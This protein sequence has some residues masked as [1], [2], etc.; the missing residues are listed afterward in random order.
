M[1]KVVCKKCK[2]AR[3][4]K[5]TQTPMGR[6]IDWLESPATTHHPICSGRERLDGHMGW[7]CKC[8]NNDLMTRQEKRMIADPV[9]PKAQEINE[10]MRNMVPDKPKFDLVAV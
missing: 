10:I 7:Q 5:L 6:M 3:Q 2:V 8:G 1:H 9:R 4:V